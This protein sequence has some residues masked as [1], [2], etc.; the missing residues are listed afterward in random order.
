MPEVMAYR[1]GGPY[2]VRGFQMSGVGTGEAFMMASGEL[3]V[4]VPFVDRI[5]DGQIKFL[6]DLRLAFFVDAGKIFHESVTDKIYERP[7]SAIT[8]GLGLRV[9]IPGIGPLSVEWGYPLTN[10]NKSGLSK[11]RFT[12]GVGEFY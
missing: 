10:T 4:P 5:K 12:F 7:G 2:T 3:R 9:F 11:G 1:L 6:N 8:T